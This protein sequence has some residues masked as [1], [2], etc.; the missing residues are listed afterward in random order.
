M[1][2]GVNAVR[3]ANLSA[4]APGGRRRGPGLPGIELVHLEKPA[5][6]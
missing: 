1:V 5:G 2:T 3:R 6:A 4:A